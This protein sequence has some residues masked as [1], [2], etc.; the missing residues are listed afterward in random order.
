MCG[1]LG[2]A[3]RIAGRAYPAAYDAARA[4]RLYEDLLDRLRASPAVKS[5]G[6]AGVSI[7]SGDEWDSSMGVEG[8]RPADGEDM[9]AFM[10]ALS[11]GYFQTMAIPILEGRDFRRNDAREETAVAIVNKKFATHFFK[12]QSA[13]GKRIGF[14]T[15]P[16]SKLTIEIIGVAADSLYE[17]PREGV[18]RQVFIPFYGSGSSAFYIR[19]TTASDAAF[20]LVRNELKQLDATM[21]VYEMKTLEGQLDETLLSDRLIALLSAG[22]GLV[23]A[24]AG[25][26][27]ARRASRIDPILALRQE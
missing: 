18:R 12:G 26:I 17:G 27:P 21:P 16:Q 3:P 20:G 25:L 1:H 9:Q 6:Q 10:N 4:G 11:P 23:S 24:A 19:T 14:G 13:L 5:A 22:F 8:H 7:L 15:G 2:H